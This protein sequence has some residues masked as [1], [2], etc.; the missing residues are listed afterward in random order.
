MRIN[1]GIN[2]DALQLQHKVQ[3]HQSKW[4]KFARQWKKPVFE[5]NRILELAIEVL[6]CWVTCHVV[7]CV[8]FIGAIFSHGFFYLTFEW[9]PRKKKE[10]NQ[11]VFNCLELSHP[12]WAHIRLGSF[13]WGNS[14]VESKKHSQSKHAASGLFLDH[15]SSQGC[16]WW[17]KMKGESLSSGNTSIVANDDTVNITWSVILQ[18]AR[19][20]L[21]F[22]N[23][24]TLKVF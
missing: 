22:C 24:A 2:Q 17:V 11:G 19:G 9:R 10:D 1:K 7:T 5:V 18:H 6:P 16:N 13:L 4:C 12:R 14:Y 3:R 20:G 8:L 15:S 23:S 21:L